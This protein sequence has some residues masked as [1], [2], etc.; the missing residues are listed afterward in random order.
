M[1]RATA[2]IRRVVIPAIAVALGLTATACQQQTVG[3]L[4]GSATASPVARTVTIA[5]KDGERTAIVVHPTTA[6]GKAALVVMLHGGLGSAKQAE[7]KYHWDD[8]A[9]RD[10]FVVAY[11]NG[12]N[13]TWNA[14]EC[15]GAAKRQNVDDVGFLHALVSQLER[16]DGV[17]P[18][19]V[20]AVGMSNGAMMTYTWACHDPGELAGI[21]PVAGALVADCPNP[22]PI[23]VV[24]IHGTADENVPINGGV[25][26]KSRT[27]VA[28][29]SLAQ[30]LAPFIAADRCADA[31]A[32]QVEPPIEHT[33]WTCANG[34]GVSTEVV[35][36]A[37]HQW[38]GG[39]PSSRA[40][41]QALGI[42]PPSNA[43][44]ATSYLWQQLSKSTL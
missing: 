20:Y 42:D 4:T 39:S 41:D 19:R 3:Q 5:T 44:D 13:A 35:E 22:R 2:A 36:G 14:G 15:C 16:T 17:D 34:G 27:D 26:A 38:P 28:Y 6:T 37:G 10:G 12:V 7:D 23:T 11:P 24:A 9:T 33:V 31:P 29:P 21:G 25:G 40:T 32:K 30:T 18:S 43:I 8:E 1:N